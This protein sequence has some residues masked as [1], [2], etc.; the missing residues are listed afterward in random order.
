MTGA[1]DQLCWQDSPNR[2]AMTRMWPN[3]VQPTPWMHVA[4]ANLA[5]ARALSSWIQLCVSM[6][7]AS[8]QSL[9]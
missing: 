1:V 3:A 7:S 2:M 4:Q 8:S 9:Q 6:L 5:R